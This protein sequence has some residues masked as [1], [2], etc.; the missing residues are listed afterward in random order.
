[1]R[2]DPKQTLLAQALASWLLARRLSADHAA[3]LLKVN[4]RTIFKWA[5]AAPLSDRS[6]KA[7]A[8]L[9]R[10]Q[11]PEIVALFLA[12]SQPSDA[13]RKAFQSVQDAAWWQER[14]QA[15]YL[16]LWPAKA[17]RRAPR[18]VVTG[19]PRRTWPDPAICYVIDQRR[20]APDQE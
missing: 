12:S 1:M 18:S 17:E 10:D 4:R 5:V 13:A 16:G 2:R 15:L 9:T 20:V 3:D 7:L 8:G 19:P 11:V 6:K 14:A